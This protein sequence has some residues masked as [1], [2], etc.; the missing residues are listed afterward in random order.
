MVSINVSHRLQYLIK[1][2]GR[3]KQYYYFLNKTKTGSRNGFVYLVVIFAF[4]DFNI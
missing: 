4:V 2:K 1:K 3:R